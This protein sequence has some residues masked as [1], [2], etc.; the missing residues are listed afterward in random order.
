MS[1][2]NKSKRT[3][4]YF[5]NGNGE[6]LATSYKLKVHRLQRLLYG[7]ITL[8]ELHLNWTGRTLIMQGSWQT[9]FPMSRSLWSSKVYVGDNGV[10]LLSS[11]I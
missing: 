9:F 10:S 4:V 6:G 2:A 5:A 11:A 1:V 8:C 7:N 3:T